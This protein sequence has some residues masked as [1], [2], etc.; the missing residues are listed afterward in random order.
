MNVRLRDGLPFVDAKLVYQNKKL[1]LHNV[2]LD[3]GSS[4]TVFAA[5]KVTTIG[6][7]QEPQDPI[8]QIRGVGGHEFVFVR[9]VESIS[10]GS[11]NAKDFEIEIGDM[12]YGI[13][14]DGIVGVDFLLS[15]NAIID[16]SKLEIRKEIQ[17]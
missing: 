2:L 8:R 3:T 13:E 5:E 12:F 17:Q 10:V 4:G 9:Q 7:F 15:T 14:I 11:L 1:D 6:L 16:L